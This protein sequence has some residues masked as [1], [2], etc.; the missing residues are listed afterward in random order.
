MFQ[1]TPIRSHFVGS[2]RQFIVIWHG[3]FIQ[4]LALSL[5]TSNCAYA[6]IQH[7]T[8]LCDYVNQISGV[9]YMGLCVPGDDDSSVVTKISVE[10]MLR[11][12]LGHVRLFEHGLHNQ[13]ASYAFEC[14]S[15]QVFLPDQ[16]KVCALSNP[17]NHC[18]TVPKDSM[19]CFDPDCPITFHS[20]IMPFQ[21]ARIKSTS[22]LLWQ[23]WL[24]LLP[25]WSLKYA[26]VIVSPISYVDLGRTTFKHLLREATVYPMIF[27]GDSTVWWPIYQYAPNTAL[28]PRQTQLYCCYSSI[29]TQ[30]TTIWWS[31]CGTLYNIRRLSWFVPQDQAY[32]Q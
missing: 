21:S 30:P 9:R 18:P 16:C 4:A 8:R 29:K 25:F 28:C 15:L 3:G 6:A 12:F 22:V 19:L 27:C 23:L 26:W 32:C 5:S 2:I 11:S 20:Q 1:S 24:T 10:T 13:S 7:I 31:Y 14:I 17:A